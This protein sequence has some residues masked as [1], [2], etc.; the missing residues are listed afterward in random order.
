MTAPTAWFNAV[1]SSYTP[2]EWDIIRFSDHMAG[3]DHTD[4]RRWAMRK[5]FAAWTRTK[6]SL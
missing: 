3:Y 5:L 1:A 6:K 2:N 4:A